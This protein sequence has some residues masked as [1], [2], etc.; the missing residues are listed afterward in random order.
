MP[1]PGGLEQT[2]RDLVVEG[3]LVEAIKLS[4]KMVEMAHDLSGPDAHW[5]MRRG[6][7]LMFRL[8]VELGERN[9]ESGLASDVRL[10]LDLLKDAQRLATR[11]THMQ[12]E[13]DH[14]HT[15]SPRAETPVDPAPSASMDAAWA[16]E[17]NSYRVLMLA[18]EAGCARRLGERAVAESQATRSLEL[19]TGVTDATPRDTRMFRKL[20]E[21]QARCSL[22]L[23]TIASGRGD[24]ATALQHARASVSFLESIVPSRV[25]L[26]GR[27]DT[28]VV[29]SLGISYYNVGAELEHLE[30]A[31]ASAHAQRRSGDVDVRRG[32]PG[33]V[34]SLD[35]MT[36]YK[37]ALQ[38]ANKHPAPFSQE[39]R[40]AFL[41]TV[42]SYAAIVPPPKRPRS[43]SRKKRSSSSPRNSAK[44]ESRHSDKETSKSRRKNRAPRSNVNQSDHTSPLDVKMSL[45]EAMEALGVPMEA[46]RIIV[47]EHFAGSEE[48]VE[49]SALL[50]FLRKI[51]TGPHAGK[52]LARMRDLFGSARGFSE[53]N[54]DVLF[55]QPDLRAIVQ[56]GVE[57][58]AQLVDDLDPAT[59]DAPWETFVPD[60]I[61]SKAK[62]DILEAFDFGSVAPQLT[63]FAA[64]D[65]WETPANFGAQ[66]V[67]LR[68]LHEQVQAVERANRTHA[69]LAQNPVPVSVAG[70]RMLE[71]REFPGGMPS[72]EMALKWPPLLRDVEVEYLTRLEKGHR[73]GFGVWTDVR[74]IALSSMLSEALETVG[75]FVMEHPLLLVLVAYVM[76]QL[77]MRS[78]PFPVVEGSKV[79]SIASMADFKALIQECKNTNAVLVVDY[80]ATWCPPCRRAA[81]VYGEM[82]KI[83]K[84]DDV[85]FSKVNVDEVRE[86]ASAHGI[87]AMP[88]FKIFNCDAKEVHSLR[89]WNESELR[90]MI[91]TSINSAK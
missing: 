17:C 31:A 91:V 59:S 29:R 42:Q 57:D 75:G 87:Q 3:R 63:G 39:V 37:K 36:W 25:T 33:H 68:S 14:Q 21:G 81:P 66:T 69:I 24:H 84:E 26:R 28:I 27:F 76:M 67:R 56:T 35:P 85:V 34:P 47:Q 62:L 1:G 64:I 4:Q 45:M 16:V 49:T 46:L 10:A 50:E 8:V 83:Y 22:I 20:Q 43:A 30:T 32:E 60:Q 74:G 13:L 38:V 86:L 41:R 79:R 53:V 65:T 12:L 7:E 77:Y 54:L 23:C 15:V 89:G 11:V 9:E 90:N 48:A 78:R 70:W 73:C 58:A 52:A 18:C 61:F 19:A 51:A 82:S 55:S 2:V 44:R 40:A 6:S 72:K 80:Y 5:R 88:T 71:D